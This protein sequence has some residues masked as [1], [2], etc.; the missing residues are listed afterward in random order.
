M[1]ELFSYALASF[2]LGVGLLLVRVGAVLGNL[3]IFP[4]ARMSTCPHLVGWSVLGWWCNL[5]YF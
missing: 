4:L 3:G 1:I 5:V 2:S